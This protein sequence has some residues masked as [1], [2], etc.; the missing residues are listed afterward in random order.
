[1]DDCELAISGTHK[2]FTTVFES[3]GGLSE[4]EKSQLKKG[5]LIVRS[6]EISKGPFHHVG[7]YCGRSEVIDFA[8]NPDVQQQG[9]PRLMSASMTYVDGTV[10][11]LGL[12][13]FI[14]ENPFRVLRLKS[15]TSEEDFDKRV[16]MAMNSA[17]KYNFLTN[18]CM[19]F[20][21]G[22]LKK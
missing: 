7:T 16:T 4:S 2:D 11:K 10:C 22:L 8:A 15:G 21:M 17:P 14:K 13:N 3:K 1:M 12:I 5:D 19:H 9:L 6:M 20:A 18:N